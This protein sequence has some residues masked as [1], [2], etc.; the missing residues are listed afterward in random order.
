M[1]CV[2][3]LEQPR[4]LADVGSRAYRL[5]SPVVAQQL[6]HAFGRA[7][8]HVKKSMTQTRSPSF[9]ATAMLAAIREEKAIRRKRSRLYKSRL[10]RFSHEI[11]AL[12]NE[13]ASPS[14]IR[15]WLQTT[16]RTKVVLTT[17]IRWLE[18]HGE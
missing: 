14:E 6:R 9:D 8:S 18:K 13:G 16:K 10:D 5:T 11:L 17:V 1:L 7:C 12:R 4:Y 2:G 15:F 3:Y